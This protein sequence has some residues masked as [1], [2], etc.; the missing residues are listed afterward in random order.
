MGWRRTLSGLVVGAAGVAVVTG[1][2]GALQRA[3][4][5]SALAAL[6][7]L[8]VLPVAGF[9]GLWPALIVAVVSALAYDLFFFPP[10]FVLTPTDP[11]IVAI[12]VISAV[13]AVVVSEL[14]RR[15]RR[16]AGEAESLAREVRRI[17]EEQAALRRVATLVARG[18][19]PGEVFGSVAAEVGGLFGADVAVVFRFEPER[20]ATVVG[21]WSVPGTAFP[22]GARLRMQGV[23]VTVTVLETGRPA[24][25]ERFEG[26]PGSISDCFAQL[27]ARA[28]VGAPIS[29]EG[30]LWGAVVAAATEAERLPVGSEAS[31]AGF[32]ELVATAIANAQAQLERRGFADEQAA[33]RRVA[34]MVARAVSPEEVFAAVAAEVRRVLA[35]DLT[36]MCRYDPD[37]VLTYVGWSQS[38][39][40]GP[41]GVQVPLGGRNVARLVFETGRPA[42]IDDYGDASGPAADV[43]RPLGLRAA[44]GVPVNVAGRLWG[45]MTVASIREQQPPPAGTEER[46]AG[47]TELVATAIA[48]AQARLELRGFAEEQAALRRVAT[49]VAQAAPPEEVFGAVA[50]EAGRLLEVDF[51]ILRRFEDGEQVSVGT[52]W[53]GAGD[54]EPFP[55]G[56]RGRLGGRNVV[57]LVFET[58]RPARIDDYSVASG[59]VADAAREWGLRSAVAVP[60]SVEGR[61]WGVLAVA[62]MH[63]E[64]LPVATEARLAGF[65]ELVATAIANAQ[66]RVE[67][68]GFA[69]EQAA[70]RR[71]ATLVARAASP[72]EVFAA[73]T[74][75]A[76]RLLHVDFTSMVRFD[77][78]DA[79]TWVGSWS[80]TDA[81]FPIP[82]GTR[83]ALGGRNMPT[84]VFETDRPARIDYADASGA[85]AAIARELGIRSSVGAPISVAGRLWG[86]LA[87]VSTRDEPLPADTE[88]RLAGF[89]ELVATAIANAEAR[90]ELR[91]FAEEQAALRRVATLVARAAPPE[92]VF[93]SVTAEVGRVL[94]ADVAGMSRYDSGDAAI[95][96]GLWSR[97]GTLL[98]TQIGTRVELEGQNVTTLVFQTRR[99]A[100][101]DDYTD[102][103]GAAT[104][105]DAP[106]VAREI[107]VRSSVGAPISVEGRLW[108][109]MI[110]SSTREEPLAADTEARL[111]AFTELVAT[112]LANAQAQA[113]LTASRAR[114][115][116][117]AD[118]TRRRI[119]RDLHDGAQQRLVSLALQL[120]GARAVVPSDMDELRAQLDS[121][122]AEASGTLDELRQ[123]ARGIH[124][125]ALAT[126]GLCPALKALARRSAVPV[127]LDI[128]VDGRLPE[129][130]EIAA[131]YVAS[132]ALT[133][134]AKHAQA[135]NVHVEVLIV[136]GNG[137]GVLRVRVRDDG[138]GG[139][140][141]RG[142]SGLVGLKDRVEALGGALSVQTAP[143]A[144]STVQAELPLRSGRAVSG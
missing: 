83:A 25:T 136:E 69:D 24:G 122:A 129:Q 105:G 23:G 8:A 139:A 84:V 121:L 43:V 138:R 11:H 90:V 30:R 36:V 66:A 116:A 14:A 91:G 92:E 113:A 27:G 100:R 119:E 101:T 17:A 67:L 130:I 76:G 7:V 68:R 49:L 39:E 37:A 109:V 78:D 48:N 80:A 13:T 26:P 124:P 86:L 51:T 75:E 79:I 93:A 10:L 144:G 111:A 41:V 114:I 140:D 56:T 94:C 112:A 47:F 44:V 21:R 81:A 15:V 102:A 87:A 120:R 63:D 74:E 12:L 34:T 32:T 131:Y 55:V 38:G 118:T 57:S 65:A 6:Y 2:V 106:R 108:G 22:D 20:T 40:E 77:R 72:G 28:G 54:V 59:P 104:A 103:S 95:V 58:G 46:L 143:G 35:V 73:V 134:A 53:R 117:A 18:A 29:V 97:T 89:A 142:G 50:A 19:A 96:L 71:V 98:P 60:I 133:N 42:R 16:R 64:P 110:V 128:R 123:L 9:W 70:L 99:P 107:G 52:W 137:D 127:D 33:L 1:V 135:A 82:V 45:V 126:G 31:I 3:V 88:G 115:V 125:P 132:E 85:V 61:L 62:Y 4:P 5:V 141:P